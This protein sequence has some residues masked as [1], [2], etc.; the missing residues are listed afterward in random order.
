[1]KF[2]IYLFPVLIINIDIIIMTQATQTSGFSSADTALG[3]SFAY[4]TSDNI[5]EQFD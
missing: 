3:E 1:M 4:L 2:V 5:A